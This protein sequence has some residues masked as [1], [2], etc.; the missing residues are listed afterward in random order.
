M[1]IQLTPD[2]KDIEIAFTIP[3]E[4]SPYVKEWYQKMKKENDTPSIFIL[5]LIKNMAI[6]NRVSQINND[7]M[8]AQSD[9]EMANEKE[10]ETIL[11]Q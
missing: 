8:R 9:I 5:R 1:S 10:L 6:S 4:I 3:K 11:E 2:A 7:L